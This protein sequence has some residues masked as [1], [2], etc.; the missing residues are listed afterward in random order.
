MTIQGEVIY[1][2]QLK[3]E[4]QMKTITSSTFDVQSM[5]RI[6]LEIDSDFKTAFDFFDKE[7]FYQEG[8]TQEEIKLTI[9]EFTSK[10]SE[11]KENGFNVFARMTVVS[12]P[13]GMQTL[14]TE[15]NDEQE[16]NTIRSLFVLT[17]SQLIKR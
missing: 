14:T 17:A 8:A 2:S 12:L 10:L 16:F 9:S 4:V 1:F 15:Y 13:H 7:L 5:C 11:L 3:E 6:R